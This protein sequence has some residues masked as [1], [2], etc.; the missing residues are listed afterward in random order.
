MEL[1]FVDEFP[2]HDKFP[3]LDMNCQARLETSVL[4]PYVAPPVELSHRSNENHLIEA[5]RIISSKQ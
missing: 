3:V 5:T 1:D 2:I 4:L